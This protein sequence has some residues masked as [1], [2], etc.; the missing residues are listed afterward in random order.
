MAVGQNQWDPILGVGE[1]TTHF[2][3]YF[4]GWI[5]SGVPWEM[6]CGLFLL[7][8]LSPDLLWSPCDGRRGGIPIRALTL[9]VGTWR[10]SVPPPFFGF[11]L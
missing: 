3:T 4:S 1:F 9:P 6:G 8:S 10:G 5:E 11:P 7:V 2:R